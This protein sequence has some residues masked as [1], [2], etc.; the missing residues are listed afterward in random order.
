MG[1]GEKSGKFF[2]CAMSYRL[3]IKYLAFGNPVGFVLITDVMGKYLHI[4]KKYFM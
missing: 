1:Y 3:G 4:I 2:V